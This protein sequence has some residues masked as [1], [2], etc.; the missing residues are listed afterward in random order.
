ML[1]PAGDKF[2]QMAARMRELSADKRQQL[3]AKLHGQGVNVARLPIVPASEQGPQGLSY[4]QQRQWFLWQYD[5]LGSAYNISAALRLKG[6]LDLGALQRALAGVMER[7]QALRAAFVEDGGQVRQ[8]VRDNV[9]PVLDVVDAATGDDAQ[10][11]AFAQ[12]QVDRPFDLSRELL[13]RVGL[14]RVAA[15]DQVL[16]LTLHHIITDGWSMQV[17]IDEWLALYVAELTA[18]PAV[19]PAMA[20]QYSDYAAWQRQWLQAGEGQRQLDYWQ[21]KLGREHE[22]LQ[23][24]VDRPRLQPADR[25]GAT[26]ALPLQ[27]ALGDA[28]KALAQAQGVSPFV[29]L[30]AAFQVLLHRYSGQRQIRVGVPNANRNRAE[31]ERLIG[32][33]VNTQV[34]QAQVDGQ[35]RFSE[36]LQQVK[37]T[38]LEAQAHQDLPFEQLVEALQPERS[39]LHTPLFQVMYNHQLERGETLGAIAGTGLRLEPLALQNGGAAFDL[40]LNSY[41]GPAGLSATLNYASDIFDAATAQRMGDH[42]LNLLRSA[43]AN[44][45]Q[46]VAQMPMLDAQEQQQVLKSWNATASD[47]PLDQ[48]IHTLIEAQAA[49]TP[50]AVALVFEQQQLSYREL[51]RR[52]NRLAR[53]LIARGVQPEGLVGIALPRGVDLVLAVL[54]TLKAGAAYV[55]LDP[56]YPAQ[57]LGYMMEDSG[58]QLLL[59]HQAL[60]QQLPVPQG[61]ACV[62]LDR[63]AA[64]ADLAASDLAPRASAESRAYVIYTSG[65]TGRPKGVMVRHG[66]LTNFVTSMAREPGLTARDRVLSLTTFSFDI[67]GLELFGPLRVG[68]TLVMTGQDINLD[69]QALLQLIEDQ[70][71][72]V[73]QATPSTWRMLLDHPQ[74]DVLDGCRMLCGGEALPDELATRML[75]RASQVWNLYGP[76]ETTIWSARHLL[77]AAAPQ[78]WLGGPIA[79]TSLYMLDED[80][81]PAPVGVAGELLI[82]GDGLARGYFQRP[83]LTAERFLPNPFGAP[84]ERLYRTGDLARYRADGVVE[85]LGRIDHQVKIRGFR[86]ELGEIES[87]LLRH[88][89]VREAAVV[90]REL[91]GGAQLVGYVVASDGQDEAQLREAVRQSLKADL[92]DYMVPGHWVFLERLPLT[93]NGK[94]DRKALPAPELSSARAHGIAPR[95]ALEQQIAEVWQQVLGVAQVSV[96]DNFFERGGHSLL[97]TQVIARLKGQIDAQVTLRDLFDAPVL[98]D[99]AARLEGR[100]APVSTLPKLVA[101]G[102]RSSLPLSLAQRRL[103]VAEQFSSGSGAYGM[104][105]ALR[106]RGELSLAHLMRAFEQVVQRHEVLRTCYGADED[107]NP[108]A[109]VVEQV[110]LAFPVE[111]LSGLSRIEQET[112]V[113]EATVD[114]TRRPLDLPQAPMLRGHILRLGPAEHVL[115]FSLHHI[116]SA[117]WMQAV[118]GNELVSHYGALARGVQAELP[119]LPVQYADYAQWQLDLERS[120]VLQQQADYWQQALAGSSGRLDLPSDHPRPPRASSE[121]ASETFSLSPALTGALQALARRQGVTP[122]ITLLAAFQVLLHRLSATDDL[123]VGADVA[124]RQQ[125][126]LE[127]LI[128]FFV[129][130]LPLRSRFDAQLPFSAFLAAARETTLG[131]FEHQDLPLDMIAEASAVPR[132]AG[133]N[134]LVQVLFVM[135]NLPLQGRSID[136]ISVEVVPSAAGY[137]KFDMALFIDEQQGQWHGTWQY[138]TDVFKQARITQLVTAWMGMLEQIVSD[139][140]IRLGDIIMPSNTA[141]AT[142][143]PAGPK[144]DK[145][146]KFL[147]KPKAPAANGAASVVR[148]S[149]LNAGQVFPL[150]VEP[151]DPGLDLVAWIK[152]NREQVVDTLGKHAGILFR[153]FALR[154]MHDFEAFAEAVQPG[155]YGQYGDLPKKEGGKNTYRSTPYPQQKMILFHNESAH[156]DRWPRKQMFYCEQPS[157]VGGATPVVDCRLMYQRLPQPLRERFESKGLLYVRTFADKLD[158]S[159]QHFF[160][161]DD[162][163]EVEQRC[164]AAGIQWTWFDNDELQIR[165]PC[166]A[167]IRH[168]VTGEKTFFN[169]VQLHHTYC[170]DPDVRDDL[171]AMFGP[172]RMPRHVCYG[173]GTPIEDEVMA[174]IGELYEACAVRFDWRKGD[175]ILLDNML[176]AHARDPF[177]GPRRIVV[178]MGDMIER[179]T[180]DDAAAQPQARFEMEGTQA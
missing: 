155:L 153:G 55:P 58:L 160:K 99:L 32:F 150:L 12:A 172:E 166:P 142:A 125:P 92:P 22:R 42:W 103:W 149:L 129:N 178:A 31:T 43:V 147:K 162:R 79:N 106:L 36:L 158:V 29:L 135:N 81:A 41:D 7:H 120:G 87:R 35:A 111:D 124:G 17:L 6:R 71:V 73:A 84:G 113:A 18:R 144:A 49:R 45:D 115:L 2:A 66:A 26:V 13:V 68:A 130:I 100:R 59:S 101:A 94:L 27:P 163:A 1:N 61:V 175:V 121:G 91:A 15:E 14:L 89:Q 117:G 21:A 69:P 52:A 136:A 98:E 23:L 34:L 146:G 119:A 75:A 16:V 179:R 28:L 133:F 132:H 174:L 46:R 127:G 30:L 54:A 123:L 86:I 173:D 122:Y 112:R 114:N 140:D 157:P 169:Q 10:I 107:G 85:Y 4:A 33:F 95:T 5:P 105:M 141:A 96:S 24:P 164:S 171:L 138:A 118:L 110:A 90:A 47:Y 131:A 80:L 180:L 116:S 168:P 78:P 97:A 102:A 11:Q 62:A 60:L 126:E 40:T 50:D 64:G 93:P 72:N 143:A 70:R 134:P 57:R 161:T 20:I 156:Q 167:I 104:P 19:L 48:G 83:G 3:F 53:H 37:S 44:P 145:L 151:N 65:S 177:E 8:V 25:C 51:N 137:S 139:P 38:A 74:A 128:G 170:L 159:W 108:L 109:Q 88:P 165:T 176:A 76:T 154:D 148:E 67:F 56:G 39:N 82:G 77:S 152:A 63:E 9:L